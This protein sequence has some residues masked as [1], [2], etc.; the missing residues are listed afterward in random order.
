MEL[1]LFVS[2]L[3]SEMCSQAKTSQVGAL[4]ASNMHPRHTQP[5]AAHLA[6]RAP[7]SFILLPLMH[8]LQP[9]TYGC[10]LD[11]ALEEVRVVVVGQQRCILACK[12]V[13]CCQSHG[14]LQR[15]HL[16]AAD[17]CPRYI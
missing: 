12:R 6:A 1:S 8:L 10:T 11:L 15:R 3:R 4:H 13:D 7:A 17:W 14:A 9:H 16:L 2:I 5:P